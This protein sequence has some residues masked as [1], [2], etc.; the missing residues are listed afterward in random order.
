MELLGTGSGLY[1]A[2]GADCPWSACVQMTK[3]PHLPRALPVPLCVLLFGM[4]AASCG[5]SGSGNHN[6][7]GTT[8]VHRLVILSPPGPS[9]G[10][11]PAESRMLRVRYL[12]PE[13]RPVQD[14]RIG[15]AIQGSAGGAVLSEAQAFTDSEGIAEMQLTGGTAPSVFVVSVSAPH[16]L[17]V[18]FEV[19]VSAAGFAHIEVRPMYSGS[20]AQASFAE[21]LVG[22]QFHK[23]CSDVLPLSPEP[24]DRQRSLEVF[25]SLAVFQNLPVDVDYA[26]SV[27]GLTTEGLVLA[28]GCMDLGAGHLIPGVTQ[29][30]NLGTGDLTQSPAGTYAVETD[31]ILTEQAADDLG[32]AMAAFLPTGSCDLGVEEILLD[33]LLDA[34][35]PDALADCT[36]QSEDPLAEDLRS[37]RGQRDALGCRGSQTPGGDPSLELELRNSVDATGIERLAALADFGA[38]S[39]EGTHHLQLRSELRVVEAPFM[40]RFY[41]WHQL[42]TVCFPLMA[43]G[44]RISLSEMGATP[45]VASSMPSTRDPGP[46][47]RLTI[48]PHALSLQPSWAAFQVAWHTHLSSAN[49]PRHPWSSLWQLLQ[50]YRG[51]ASAPH[52][53]GCE[54]VVAH[55]CDTIGQPASCLPDACTE[56]LVLLEEHVT[57]PWLALPDLTAVDVMLAA[58]VVLNDEDGDLWSDRLGSPDAP[59]VWL[60]TLRSGSQWLAPASATFDASRILSP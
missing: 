51:P 18:A 57:E 24:P 10:L 28:W 30:I 11:A 7:G 40:D 2:S 50:S 41:T 44:L 37:R 42:Q 36:P 48:P 39:R 60:M 19:A 1:T 38:M 31:V 58:S 6:D 29:R 21:V 35:F 5:D 26:L 17:G 16:A 49:I 59:A 46:P 20:H 34:A 56:G 52:L 8:G 54:A 14:V 32:E 55:L 43:Q 25:N 12:D 22:V 23:R 3:L 45:L 33:C 4:T 9:I 27:R 47:P 53:T 13:D 15:F